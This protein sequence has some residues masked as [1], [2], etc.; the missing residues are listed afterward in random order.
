MRNITLIWL[1]ALAVTTT[2]NTQAKEV[3]YKWVDKN[4]VIHY[5]THPPAG[6][7]AEK[8]SVYANNKNAAKPAPKG[9]PKQQEQEQEP[10]A[11]VPATTTPEPAPSRK[12]PK[13]CEQARKNLW[14][15]KNR[16]R[17]YILDSDTGERMAMPD[18]ERQLRIE[19]TDKDI[20]EFCE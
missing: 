10:Q 16:G 12:D 20:E 3:V 7:K 18:E 9:E 15:L 11:T 17:I 5:A 19:E 2:F 4:G 1:F 14:N 8:V 6:Q 13:L